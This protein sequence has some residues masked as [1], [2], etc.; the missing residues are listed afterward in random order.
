MAAACS[1]G[2]DGSGDAGGGG[3]GGGALPSGEP[4]AMSGITALHNEV[5]QS[6]SP[7]PSE[8]LPPLTWSPEI[9]A[10]AQAYA[11]Q[12]QWKHSDNP[13]GENIYASSGGSTPQGVVSAWS[14]EAADY[15]YATDTCAD[16]CGHYTQ[17]VWATTTKLGCGK[18]TCTQNSPFGSGSWDFWVCNY[19]PP[20]NYL[21][22]KPY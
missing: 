7:A 2:D 1:S 19:D 8:P 22:Q 18:A 20:G 9:A 21:G 15:D 14:K 13:Y 11:E 6:V 17:I 4:E 10:V 16:V 12:C 5:R 3:G